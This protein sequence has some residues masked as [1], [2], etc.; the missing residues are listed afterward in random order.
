MRR[1]L[2]GMA[3]VQARKGGREDAQRRRESQPHEKNRAWAPAGPQ[4]F[5]ALGPR[6]YSREELLQLVDFEAACRAYPGHD[7][8]VVAETT[9]GAARVYLVALPRNHPSRLDAQGRQ[10]PARQPFWAHG[11]VAHI[12]RKTMPP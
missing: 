8:I 9:D 11:E 6:S 7:I 12:T 10:D 1:D 5:Y 3:P 2:F 4:H